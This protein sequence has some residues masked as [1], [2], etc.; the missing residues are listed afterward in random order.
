MDAQIEHSIAERPRAGT[1][2]AASLFQ[3]LRVPGVYARTSLCGLLMDRLGALLTKHRPQGAEVLRFP[4]VMSRRDLQRSGYLNSFPNLLGCVCALHGSEGEIRQTLQR[5]QSGDDWT[6]ALAAT[7]LVLSPAACY[8]V[9]PM[10]AERG[11]LPPRGLVFDVECDCFR[12]EPSSDPD[13]LQSFRMREFVCLGAGPDVVAFRKLW[14]ERAQSLASDLG[15]PARI[16]PASDPFFG[17]EGQ[18]RGVNQIQQSLKFELLVPAWSSEKPT[19]C[20]SFNYHQDH[21]GSIWDISDDDGLVAHTACVA[22]GM[23]RLVLALV[24]AHGA[25]LQRWPATARQALDLGE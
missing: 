22:F 8:P 23:D 4:P 1:T 3:S 16:A 12:C 19:A 18:M 7:D 14:L 21:F 24:F 9:Y 20:M 17:R 11:T 15:L 10:A 25:D 6:G 13:R 2:E 5:S